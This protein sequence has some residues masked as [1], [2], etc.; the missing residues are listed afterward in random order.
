MRQQDIIGIV[1]MHGFELVGTSEI[2]ANPRDPANH[3][4]GVWEMPPRWGTKRKS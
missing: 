4:R 1:E 2:N 3:E